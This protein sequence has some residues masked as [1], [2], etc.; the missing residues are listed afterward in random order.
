MWSL[1]VII[2]KNDQ[3]NDLKRAFENAVRTTKALPRRQEFLNLV[4]CGHGEVIAE[5]CAGQIPVGCN[6]FEEDEVLS[7]AYSLA[8]EQVR[9]N[10]Q[11][12]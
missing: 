1:E 2:E 5:A 3:K 12:V 10:M 4:T 8:F 11:V 7:Q 6:K 9:R